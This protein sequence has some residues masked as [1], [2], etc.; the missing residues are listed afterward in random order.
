VAE[1]RGAIAEPGNGTYP[2]W[3]ARHLEEDGS[4]PSVPRSHHIGVATAHT[5]AAIS[6]SNVRATMS[7]SVVCLDGT[8]FPNDK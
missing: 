8:L 1:T 3:G 6:S 4:G 5:P 2:V 7:T